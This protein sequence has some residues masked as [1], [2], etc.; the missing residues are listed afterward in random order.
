MTKPLNLIGK[1]FFNLTVLERVANSPAGKQRVLCQCICGK[2]VI[3][4]AGNFLNGTMRSCGCVRNAKASKRMTKHG[5]RANPL[6]FRW[7]G[8]M[9]RCYNPNSTQYHNYGARGITV[10]VR[11]RNSVQAFIDDVGKPPFENA[12]LDRINNNGNYEPNNV[13]WATKKEQSINR[14]CTNL[15]EF[16]GKKMSQTDWGLELFGDEQMV[17]RRLGRG[18]SIEEALTL[19]KYTK[20]GF[21]RR[22][23]AVL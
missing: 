13:R 20:I 4:T 23:K 1:T 16:D 18:W 8:I 10:C 22:Q 19:P 7:N 3:A 14:R 2:Q 17:T 6:Y 15:I 21:T 5:A 9:A 11:W 12:T